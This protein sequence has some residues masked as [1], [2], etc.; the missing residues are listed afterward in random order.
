M[1]LTDY[2]RAMGR[3][4]LVLV[5]LPAIAV[6]AGYAILSRRPPQFRASALI[7]LPVAADAPTSVV[8]QANSD[9]I[10]AISSVATRVATSDTTGVPRRSVK[11]GLAV[12]PSG[13]RR[14]VEVTFT[15]SRRIG[16]D[17][18]VTTAARTALTALL[19][20]DVDLKRKVV[21]ASQAQYD[22]SRGALDALGADGS[23]L[24][25]EQYRQKIA[26]LSQLQLQLL[27]AQSTNGTTDP[28]GRLVDNTHAI[29]VYTG[30]IAAAQGDAARLVGLVAQARPAEDAVQSALASLG[31]A[32]RDLEASKAALAS[33]DA[34]ETIITSP[35]SKVD[36]AEQVLRTLAVIVSVA[37]VLAVALLVLLELM[38]PSSRRKA[39]VLEAGDAATDPPAEADWVP[40][41]AVAQ[42]ERT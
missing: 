18:V 22:A 15:T 39:R 35:V 13:S 1:E 37:V 30:A 8:I 11:K 20:P 36:K 29:N 16:A 5:M 41:A 31:T 17:A 14:T 34:A 24:P 3:R 27:Q 28:S 7:R 21:E 12:P 40:T 9:F 38:S 10:E 32:Q 25:G 6:G 19:Q 33:V 2:L 23:T 26:Q 42:S 4:L